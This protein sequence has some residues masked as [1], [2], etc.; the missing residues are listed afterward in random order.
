M[1]WIFSTVISRKNTE[2]TPLI[3]TNCLIQFFRI[4]HS[5]QQKWVKYFTHFSEIYSV[6]FMEKNGKKREEILI[7]FHSTKTIV[8]ENIKENSPK[9]N[10]FYNTNKSFSFL[11]K[12][13][14]II[15]VLYLQYCSF[16]WKSIYRK[17]WE[18]S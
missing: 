13:M 2:N 14:L 1:I 4:F 3:Y 12:L 5:I 17:W 8:A 10:P 9:W 7:D 11:L 16:K 6:I 15:L 18:N